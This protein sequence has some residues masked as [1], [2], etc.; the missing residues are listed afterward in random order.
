MKKQTFILKWKI[1][2]Y[3]RDKKSGV[4]NAVG[5]SMYMKSLMEGARFKDEQKAD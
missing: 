5:Q 2:K 1:S 3:R 4:S